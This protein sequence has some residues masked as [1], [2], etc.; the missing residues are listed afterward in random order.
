MCTKF[1]VDS[2]SRFPFRAWTNRQTH[3]QRQLN[4]LLT[5]E[6]TPAWIIIIFMHEAAPTYQRAD[7]DEH[8][9]QPKSCCI[10]EF[11]AKP[12]HRCLSCHTSADLKLQTGQKSTDPVT[13]KMPNIGPTGLRF[14]VPRD[15]TRK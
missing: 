8:R 2:S 11:P 6:A 1:G 13:T 3:R 14:Y 4:A 9:Q 5:S 10:S 12:S 15:I 7:S